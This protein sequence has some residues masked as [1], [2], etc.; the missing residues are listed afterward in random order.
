MFLCVLSIV[1]KCEMF[2]F[3]GGAR[4]Y[5]PLQS[6]ENTIA[7]PMAKVAGDCSDS[8]KTETV[9]KNEDDVHTLGIHASC[10]VPRLGAHVQ[11]GVMYR[12]YS[13]LPAFRA[14]I[15][16]TALGGL[17]GTRRDVDTGALFAFA[18]KDLA[19]AAHLLRGLQQAI[20]HDSHGLHTRPADLGEDFDTWFFQLASD[21]HHTTVS[22]TTALDATET[23]QRLSQLVLDTIPGLVHMTPFTLHS[24]YGSVGCLPGDPAGGYYLCTFSKEVLKATKQKLLWDMTKFPEECSVTVTGHHLHCFRLW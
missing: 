4:T 13:C 21:T 1:L 20:A 6:K 5:S 12:F 9:P 14:A 7:R 17:L 19:G 18:R 10:S 2:A 11:H 24:P 15:T 8:A 23:A 16:F 22:D 3:R